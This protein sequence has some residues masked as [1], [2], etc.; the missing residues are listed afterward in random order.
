MATIMRSMIGALRRRLPARHDDGVAA[1][2]F[3]LLAPMFVMIFAG[4]VNVGDAVVLQIRLD[5]AVAA[6]MN[7]ALVNASS[8]SSTSGATLAGNIATLVSTSAGGTAA[9]VTV[10]V[11]NGPSETITNG[12]TATSGTA[13]N[14]NN[15]YCPTGSPSSWT[16][17][18][19]VTCG[20]SCNG[21]ITAGKFVTVT[22]SY[23]F[24]PFFS[25][26]NFGLGSTITIGSA[27]QTQ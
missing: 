4:G 5:G 2:E 8:V 7:Y 20:N 16:W 9:N 19:A 22:A 12:T 13:S 24:T 14:A 3:G 15:C 18:N 17:G 1:L 10:V 11:N 25:A 27:A 26:F 23:S 21:G 6:G